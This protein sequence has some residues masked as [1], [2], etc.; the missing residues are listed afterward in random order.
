MLRAQTS[1]HKDTGKALIICHPQSESG[2]AL[3]AIPPDHQP[4][5][6]LSI[7]LEWWV[8]SRIGAG[9]APRAM[10]RSIPTGG[11]R[12]EGEGALDFSTEVLGPGSAPWWLCGLRY[13]G[14]PI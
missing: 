5:P 8:C 3:P 1:L 7:T 9:R 10:G 12:G 13:V 4:C 14:E 2:A 11:P 6:M